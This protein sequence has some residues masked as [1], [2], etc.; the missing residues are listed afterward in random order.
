MGEVAD[1]LSSFKEA[2]LSISRSKAG[3]GGRRQHS[4]EGF[5]QNVG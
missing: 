5:Q 2:K 1:V 3:V 4:L